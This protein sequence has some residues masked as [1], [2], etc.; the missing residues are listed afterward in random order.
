[1]RHSGEI[2]LPRLSRTSFSRME[3]SFLD[4]ST[5][6]LNMQYLYMYPYLLPSTR[7]QYAVLCRWEVPIPPARCDPFDTCKGS[8]HDGCIVSDAYL[9]VRNN[10]RR[11]DRIIGYRMNCTFTNLYIEVAR[12][13]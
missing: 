6:T 10:N 13:R 1:M 4:M 5:R 2:F 8:E 12:I 9:E 11:S 3:S 7:L